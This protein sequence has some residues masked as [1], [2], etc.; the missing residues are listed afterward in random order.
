M[1]RA[2]GG[3]V[4]RRLRAAAAGPWSREAVLGEPG[5]ATVLAAGLV[6]AGVAMR[7]AAPFFMDL[8]MDGDTYAAM[9]HALAQGHG[10]LLPWGDVTTWDCTGPQQAHHYPPAYPAYL[11]AVY[12][13]FGFGLWQT[14]WAAVL[15]SLA[16]LAVVFACTQDLLGRARAWLVTALVAVE[17]HLVWATGTNFSE[18]MVLLFFAL[19]MWGILK[20]IT[21][22]RFIIVAGL[23]AGLA[24]LTRAGMGSFFILAGAAG[25]AWRFHYMRWQVLRNR[26]YLLAIA[27]FLGCVGLWALRNLAAFG[28]PHWETSSYQ[29]YTQD[30]AFA[31]AALFARGLLLKAPLFAAF[32]LAYMLPLAPEVRAS[33]RRWREERESALW[34]A[35]VLVVVIGW[36]LASMFWTYEQYDVWWL[37]NHRYAVI[38][39]LPVAWMAVRHAD[40]R[41]PRLGFPARFALLGLAMLAV[42]AYAFA[43]P[44]QFPETHAAEALNP[45]LQHGTQVGIEGIIVKYSFYPY[46]ERRDIVVYG[47][48]ATAQDSCPG[49]DPD[50][51][52][53]LLRP[54]YH[55]G[56]A[57]YLQ[58]TVSYADGSEP[59]T[60]TVYVR[61][62]PAPP[63]PRS[64]G[65]NLA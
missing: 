39:L 35:I 19:T 18:N 45:S 53:S 61:D 23:A 49:Q 34:L 57:V 25:F 10:F 65:C 64:P 31:H 6:A 43:A 48:R 3:A 56:Y 1:G 17:P 54:R 27:I 9:G 21:E 42:S 15:M 58:R 4:L 55:P 52:L 51:I 24:Y 2:R 40:L 14:K 63:G 46:L 62:H 36:V 47:C 28:W 41:A 59:F 33:L 38:A 26:S 8:R 32:A 50:F 22:Q 37:D 30:F 11:G 12:A 20:G 60:A 7:L 16:A 13:L 44:T 29:A 5:G